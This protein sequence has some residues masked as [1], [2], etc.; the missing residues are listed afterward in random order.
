MECGRTPEVVVGYVESKSTHSFATP[1]NSTPLVTVVSQVGM[2]DREGSWA[3]LTGNTT[4]NYF[5]V[6]VDEDQTFD[7][8]RIHKPEEVDYI[9]FSTIGAIQT[10]KP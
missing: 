9:V 1:F 10:F 8:E 3:V 2:N 4:S 6:A 5:G 7:I